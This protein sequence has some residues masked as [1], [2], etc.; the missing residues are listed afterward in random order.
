MEN[1]KLTELISAVNG[2]FL[3]GNP[4]SLVAS[5]SIDSRSLRKGDY[6]FA[7]KGKN[8]DG[9]NHLIHAIEKGVSGLVVSKMDFDMGD[10]FPAPPSIILVKDTHKA[11]GDLAAYYRNKW[12]KLPVISVTGSNGKTST[13]EM[14]ASI[15]RQKGPTL[16]NTGNFNNQIGLPM[17]IF[18]L[19]LSHEFAVLEMG[20]SWPGEIK[21]LAE[22]ASPTIGVI[23]NIGSAH[24]ENFRSQENVFTEKMS[25]IEALPSDGTAVLNADDPFLSAAITKLRKKAVTFGI[26][27]PSTVTC[28]NLKL[29]PG[30]PTFDLLIEGRPVGNVILP[31]FGRFNVYNAL[32]AAAAAHSLGIPPEAIRRGLES[33]VV[34]NMRMNVI[35]LVSGLTLVVDAY[36]ANPSSMKEALKTFVETFPDRDK[37]AVLGDMLELGDSAEPEH[38]KLGELLNTLPLN[39]SFLFGPM[40]EHAH[41]AVK[42]NKSKYFDN[43]DKLINELRS[44]ISS[45][46]VIFFKASRSMH[47]EE[48][49]DVLLLE[50]ETMGKLSL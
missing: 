1:L 28:K 46:G 11:L 8:F 39:Q 4:R 12:A 43:K 47:F 27:N 13:K 19:S 34:P 3:L 29:W 35:N 44:H 45:N 9:H 41:N 14:I 20:T 42:D 21:R 50:N 7:L 15:L 24:L 25:L 22:I 36:N 32:A 17:T 26:D 33:F 10:P 48:V 38:R 2:E 5:I 6:F 37:I 18:N 16:S 31:V 23:T 40:M 30:N 49:I